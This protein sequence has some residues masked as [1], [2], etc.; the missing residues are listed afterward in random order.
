MSDRTVLARTCV[1]VSI[2]TASNRSARDEPLSDMTPK[3]SNLFTASIAVLALGLT[4]CSDDDDDNGNNQDQTIS[5]QLNNLGLT[6]LNTAV[7][8]AGLADD[9]AGPG[10]F[11]LFG[12]TN[13]AFAAAGIDDAFLMDPA[14]QPVIE[15]VVSYHAANGARFSGDLATLNTLTTLETT[16]VSVDS[17][18]GGLAINDAIVVV[19]NQNASNGVIHQLD[20][21]LRLPNET[22]TDSLVTDGFLILDELIGSVTGLENAVNSG[23]F[24]VLAPSDAAFNALAPPQ[25]LAFYRDAANVDALTELLNNHLIQIPSESLSSLITTGDVAAFE[26]GG[27]MGGQRLFFGD[28]SSAAP[29]VNG[30]ISFQSWNRPASGGFIHSIDDVITDPGDAIDV[31][32][33]AGFATLVSLVDQAGLTA[34][35]RSPGPFTI[36]APTD[37]AF[38]DFLTATGTTIANGMND[39]ELAALLSYHVVA[40]A[41]Q[42]DELSTLATVTTVQGEDIT[43]VVD[44]SGA[45]TLDSEPTF[46]ADVDLANV[47]ANNAVIHVIDAVLVP[48]GFVLPN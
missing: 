6:T 11:T 31:A 23:D 24:T 1:G 21:V 12:P 9:L 16:D 45:I 42:A 15:A 30:N 22:T 20:R 35:L 18:N 38:T 46:S 26:N 34:T 33:G 14:N 32:T 43:I 7:Q 47:F 5:G 25:D 36:F 4:A 27:G 41:I 17:V 3:A 8:V 40:N 28:T 13:A 19:A 37:Q 2:D 44:P 48:P 10:P 29:T 39:M